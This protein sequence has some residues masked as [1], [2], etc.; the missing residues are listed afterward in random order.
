[1]R[2]EFIQALAVFAIALGAGLFAFG[3]HLDPP[4]DVTNPASVQR[5]YSIDER[6]HASA[7]VA[8]GLGVS[9][10]TFGALA[11]AI[12]WLNDVFARRSSAASQ[13]ST[14]TRV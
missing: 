7:A 12:P 11:I 8:C 10:M 6:T 13:Q 9:L 4:V 1:M 5:A 14:S 3:R 2:R